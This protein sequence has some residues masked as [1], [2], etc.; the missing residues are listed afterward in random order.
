M[1][2]IRVILYFADIKWNAVQRSLQNHFKLR[3]GKEVYKKV[4]IYIEM[5]LLLYT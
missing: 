3:V 2:Y 4:Y 5:Y 1:E